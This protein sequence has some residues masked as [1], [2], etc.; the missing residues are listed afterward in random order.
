MFRNLLVSIVFFIGP[1]L[2]MFIARNLVLIG[3]VWLKSRHEKELEQKIIDITPIHN[4]RHPNW[5]VIIVVMISMTCAV[6]V[7][8]ELQNKDD[9][10]PQEYV[11]A[12]TDDSGKI[13]PGH[14]QPKAPA[15]D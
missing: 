8:L 3:M 13:I 6:T 9:V 10:V 1:A 11:P 14:W 7:F 4:H 12:Y 2:L 5:F 15:S